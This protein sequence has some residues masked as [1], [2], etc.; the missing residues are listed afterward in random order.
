MRVSAEG[1]LALPMLSSG[2]RASGLLPAELEK[3][4][5]AKLSD[6]GILVKPVVMVTVAE[7][8]SR[9]ISVMGAVRKPVT[10][11]AVGRITVLDALARAEGLS[12]DAGPE[13]LLTRI[14]ANA[15]GEPVRDVT[16]IPV[17][18]LIDQA[19]PELN[20]VLTGDEEI[21]VPDVDKMTLPAISFLHP[22]SSALERLMCLGLDPKHHSVDADA[23]KQWH[24]QIPGRQESNPI[25]CRAR[26]L[27]I[28]CARPPESHQWL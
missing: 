26:L 1:L 16:R 19:K 21:R 9:P 4:I 10:L 12:P 22:R 20:I 7:Y 15:N 27:Q 11:Q 18:E 8:H 14:R 3:A 24:C 13:I 6:E 28:R 2:V 25:A 17:R 23:P 5:A